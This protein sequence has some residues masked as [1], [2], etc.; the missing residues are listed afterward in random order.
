MELVASSAFPCG[1]PAAATKGAAGEDEE[2][3]GFAATTVVDV[4]FKEVE[5]AKDD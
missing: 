5:G 3:E 4:V 2:E 1:G